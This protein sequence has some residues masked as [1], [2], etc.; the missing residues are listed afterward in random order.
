MTGRTMHQ[1]DPT[2]STDSTDSIRASGTTDS[3]GAAD[4]ATETLDGT[5]TAAARAVG[6]AH[7]AS[8]AAAMAAEARAPDTT[9]AGARLLRAAAVAATLPYLALKTA[10]LAG[11]DI[12]IPEGS[13]L[14]EPTVFFTVANA[15]TMAMDAAVIVLALLLTRPW[16]RRVPAPLLLVPAFTATGLL[17]P[18][19]AGFPAQLVLRAVGLGA[20]PAARAAGESF[21]HGW[22]YLVV[23]G[24]FIVQGLAL[25]G[26]FVPYAR[27]RW[28]GVWQGPG[29]TR[30]PSPTGVA[31]GAAAALGTVLGALYVYWAFGG[32]A[33][34]GA[35][36]AAQHSA[37]TGAVSAVHAVCALLAGWCAVLLARGGTRRPVWP[38]AAGWTGAAA[39]LCWGLYLLAVPLAPGIGEGGGT[40]SVILLAYAAQVV[41]GCLAA[42]VLTAFATRRRR[43][44]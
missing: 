21:L 39:A 43:P 10:W 38:L 36:R 6:A 19:I 16:G 8:G 1:T 35:E 24:G 18:I 26:L 9:G 20:D 7:A 37:E 5:G 44:A 3:I 25:A 32:T 14:L 29:G 15:V 22:V 34:L 28:G 27:R 40:P 4:T 41:T 17:T 42:A 31:A 30:L 13:V 11:S 2:D 33:W 12:G 23:Y